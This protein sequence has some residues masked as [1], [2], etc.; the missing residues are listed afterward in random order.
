MY[1]LWIYRQALVHALS[2]VVGNFNQLLKFVGGQ[3]V[4]V[5]IDRV[6]RFVVFPYLVMQVW[7]RGKPR[8][9]QVAD[10]IASLHLL[11]VF[12]E[13]FLHVGVHGFVAKAVIDNHV[14]T[15]SLVETTF[16]DHAV[17]GGV[18]RGTHGTRE[19]HARVEF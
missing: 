15:V 5:K 12:H 6:Y 8:A 3:V 9:T 10:D 19:V 7:S 16:N 2:R 14:A 17:A 11:P 1:F 18:N 13:Y 4:E